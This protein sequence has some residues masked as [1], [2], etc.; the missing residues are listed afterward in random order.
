MHRVDH[1]TAK[2]VR[3]ATLAAGTPGYFFDGD[4]SVGQP[5]TIL[6]ADYMN[7]LQEELVSVLTTN[8]VALDKTASNQL[9]RAIAI[10]AGLQG[11]AVGANTLTL[12][13][14]FPLPSY[15]GGHRIFA[16]IA[17]DNTGAVT[18]NVSALGAKAIKTMDGQQLKAKDL[19]AGMIA[20][21]FFDGADYRLLNGQRG[22]TATAGDNS[23][24]LA[25]TAF[26][27][28]ADNVVLATVL[29]QAVGSNLFVWQQQGF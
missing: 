29:A 11:A 12:A 7:A 5:P 26:V 24:T 2:T 22:Y 19:R 25:T 23:D 6:T 27:T 13:P 17:A 20:E 16:K 3:P 10:A 18:I 1:P 8:G 28:A 4:V 21:L 15:L 9:A 14:A